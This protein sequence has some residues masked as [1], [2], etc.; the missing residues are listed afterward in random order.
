MKWERIKVSGKLCE[1]H[2]LN[3]VPGGDEIFLLQLEKI[4]CVVCVCV[5]QCHFLFLVCKNLNSVILFLQIHCRKPSA[6]EL[7]LR[8]VQCFPNFFRGKT[9]KIN[10]HIPRN[11]CL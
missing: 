5:F 4:L 2:W 3:N 8:V 9:H 11:Y 7:M 10:F 1:E 6:V